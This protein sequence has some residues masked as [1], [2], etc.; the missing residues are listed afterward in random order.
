MDRRK[1]RTD[2]AVEEQERLTEEAKRIKGVILEEDE[3]PPDVH[4][5]RVRI[6]DEEGARVMGKPVGTYLTLESRRMAQEDEDYHRDVSD[7][8]A[9]KL[10]E[11]LPKGWNSLLVAGLGNHHVTSDSLGPRVVDNLWITRHLDRK[12]RMI[13][14]IVPGVMAQTGMESAEIIKGIVRETRPDV[15][16]A[17]DALAARSVH[18]LGSTIQLSDTGIQPGSGVGNHRNKLNRES[19]GVPVIAVGVPTVVS[20]AAI[21]YDTLDALTTVLDQSDVTSSIS[22]TIRS[23]DM[24]EQYQLIQELLHP[25]LGPMFV[26]PKDIDAVVKRLSF[27]ISEGM[28]M[29]FHA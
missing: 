22:G 6:L 12:G 24:E 10:E 18:R 20:A 4:I 8:F 2:L 9:E 21:V 29:A 1:I 3:E 5:T 28:N 27:T 13:S 19:L 26:T 11:L 7:V 25:R 14:G 17:I 16:V 15:V 23:M